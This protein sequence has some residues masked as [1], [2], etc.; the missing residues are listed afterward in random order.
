VG[1]DVDRSNEDV[2]SVTNVV[3]PKRRSSIGHRTSDIG[4]RTCS[5]HHLAP[6]AAK[7]EQPE[8]RQQ[9]EHEADRRAERPVATRAE[10]LLDE[11]AHPRSTSVWPKR[12]VIP[13]TDNQPVASA[14]MDGGLC[15]L[16]WVALPAS[17]VALSGSLVSPGG[18]NHQFGS[19]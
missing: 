9:Y 16:R 13:T 12:L 8:Q 7:A 15:G 14:S 5:F 11:V 17:G 18:A 10:L 19:E 2:L 1:L 6:T 3:M 4:H